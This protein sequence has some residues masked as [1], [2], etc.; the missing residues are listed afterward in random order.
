MSIS[1]GSNADLNYGWKSDQN[2][3]EAIKRIL[4][5]LKRN[6]VDFVKKVEAWDIEENGYIQ[7]S[8]F[9]LVLKRTRLLKDTE[10]A[11]ISVLFN[12][13]VD[14]FKDDMINYKK[15]LNSIGIGI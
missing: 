4:G 1:E 10:E 12:N 15:A 14:P 13:F 7:N 8:D 2:K 9:K 11:V 6:G 5:K 3:G